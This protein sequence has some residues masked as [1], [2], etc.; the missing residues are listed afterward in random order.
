M[1]P[2]FEETSQKIEPTQAQ[3]QENAEP[4]PVPPRSP[5][6]SE[7]NQ[8]SVEKKEER[9]EPLEPAITETREE[10]RPEVPTETQEQAP[11]AQQQITAESQLENEEQ[12]AVPSQNE[13]QPLQ[14][15]GLEGDGIEEA[16]E[17]SPTAVNGNSLHI[18]GEF[19][20]KANVQADS[21]QV[22]ADHVG[23]DA[24][25]ASPNGDVN[26]N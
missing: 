5:P 4:P 8:E 2:V 12:N 17:P 1:P 6:E 26:E 18:V 23:V 19:E 21:E 3:A 14:T 13:E 15:H 25:G 11:V 22:A 16:R 20:T 10:Q 9:Q 7:I 24:E